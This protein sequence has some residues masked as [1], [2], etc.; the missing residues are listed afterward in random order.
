MYIQ[1]REML[2]GLKDSKNV[3]V[4]FIKKKWVTNY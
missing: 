2:I 1:Q 3:C 4:Q